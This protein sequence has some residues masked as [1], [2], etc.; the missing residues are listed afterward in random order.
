MD[1]R[2]E[3]LLYAGMSC[4][5]ATSLR[6]KATTICGSN[7]VGRSRNNPTSPDVGVYV[8]QEANAS[9]GKLFTDHKCKERKLKDEER[10]YEG[11]A[12]TCPVEPIQSKPFHTIGVFLH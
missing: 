6:C 10:R 2:S 9:R 4:G 12:N 8:Q 7:R 5:E 11:G 3:V 1:S